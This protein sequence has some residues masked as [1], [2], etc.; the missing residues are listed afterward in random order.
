LWEQAW[1][2]LIDQLD[3]ES[4]VDWNEGFADGTFASAKKGAI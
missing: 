1:C 2:Q 4:K 3:R